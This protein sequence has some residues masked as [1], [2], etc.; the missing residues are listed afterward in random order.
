VISGSYRL[1]LGQG[2]R[3]FPN[4]KGAINKLL[5]GWQAN[6][7]YR[8]ESGV[9]IT[10]SNG[11]TLG[12]SAY[13]PKDKR[14]LSRWFD[15]S[16]FRLRETLEFAATAALPDVRTHGTNNLDVSLFKDT[17]I[18]ERLTLQIRAEA[19]NL[20]NRVAFGAPNATVGSASFGVISTQVNFSRQ[21]QFAA[22]LLW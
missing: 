6:A 4:A 18:L 21:L 3:F 14:T 8:A 19:F 7:V 9:P 12:R 10:I 13:L 16:A 11:E 20:A 15:T 5:E 1:P 2:Q 22:K 17:R